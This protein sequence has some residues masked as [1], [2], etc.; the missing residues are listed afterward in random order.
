MANFNAARS[1]TSDLEGGFWNDPSVGWTY[2]GITKKFY[3]TWPGWKRIELMQLTQFRGRAIPRYTI[4]KDTVLDTLVHIFYES[5]FWKFLGG[6]FIQNQILANFLYDFF[7]H[8]QNDAIR[9]M[10]E[11]ALTFKPGISIFQTK[12]SADVLSVMNSVPQGFYLKIRNARIYYYT[13]KKGFSRSIR[14]AFLKR[15]DKFPVAI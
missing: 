2:A 9:V 1:F 12:I 4:F 13:T 14:K 6:E 7:V 15:V 8:K 3:P 11:V 10:N 5:T